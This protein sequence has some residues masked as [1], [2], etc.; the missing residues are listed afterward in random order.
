MKAAPEST[1]SLHTR[2]QIATLTSDCHLP[3][4]A[5]PLLLV[6]VVVVVALL[7]QVARGH[8]VALELPHALHPAPTSQQ[9]CWMTGCEHHCAA[10]DRDAT[11]SCHPVMASVLAGRTAHHAA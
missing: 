1:T 7:P 6:E 8:G 2:W 3:A 5:P 11:A 9:H 10:S 4:C